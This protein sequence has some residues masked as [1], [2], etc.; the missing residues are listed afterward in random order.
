MKLKDKKGKRGKF[1]FNIYKGTDVNK[2]SF[3]WI[4]T[5]NH[6]PYR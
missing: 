6:I 4:C 3:L 5:H 1:G 2:N